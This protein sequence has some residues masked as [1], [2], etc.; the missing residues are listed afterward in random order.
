M[1]STSER[2]RSRERLVRL[3]GGDH[4]PLDHISVD[5]PNH[6]VHVRSAT[7]IDARSGGAQCSATVVSATSPSDADDDGQPTTIARSG[8]DSAARRWA[9]SMPAGTDPSP[10]TRPNPR[11]SSPNN[12]GAN[13]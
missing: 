1:R 13:T 5:R 9:S 10:R 6:W 11:S 3:D 2:T 7:A 12:S 4:P 8:H